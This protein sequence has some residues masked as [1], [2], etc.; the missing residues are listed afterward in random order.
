M[1]K[2]QIK[3]IRE[4]NSKLKGE[5]REATTSHEDFANEIESGSIKQNM[6]QDQMEQLKAQIEQ[7]EELVS[8]K[9]VNLKSLKEQKED[10]DRESVEIAEQLAK[11]TRTGRQPRINKG[12]RDKDR[13]RSFEESD[14]DE[15]CGKFDIPECPGKEL[16]D[17]L[18]T[19]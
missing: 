16:Y 13:R 9:I 1:T 3:S 7:L 5:L 14:D 4:N 18:D 12:R 19:L 6:I 17:G 11:Y 8:V 2:E 15:G 10:A